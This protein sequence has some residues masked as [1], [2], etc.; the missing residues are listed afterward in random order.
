ML[1]SRGKKHTFIS[2]LY[3]ISCSLSS[4]LTIL[5]A[6]FILSSL[7]HRWTCHLTADICS[8]NQRP[9]STYAT[10]SCDVSN[11]EYE[12]FV[13]IRFNDHNVI[14]KSNVLAIHFCNWD[15]TVCR[16][17]LPWTGIKMLIRKTIM[18][19]NWHLHIRLNTNGLRLISIK[20]NYYGKRVGI[21]L[22]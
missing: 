5:K 15:L 4:N 16:S 13:K 12:T 9:G 18:L 3:F 10:M 11:V 19:Q 2:T 22:W 20:T 7:R 8:S 17:H 14:I 21:L 6:T 1:I